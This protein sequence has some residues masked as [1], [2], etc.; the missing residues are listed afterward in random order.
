MD[1]LKRIKNKKSE[2]EQIDK[3]T[4]KA[5]EEMYKRPKSQ[6][7][8]RNSESFRNLKPFIQLSQL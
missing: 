4:E 6:A 3:E 7:G 2:R 8:T 5:K 1:L